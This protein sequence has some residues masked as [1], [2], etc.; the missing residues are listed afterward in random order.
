MYPKHY[1]NPYIRNHEGC[2]NHP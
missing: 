2:Y 1:P